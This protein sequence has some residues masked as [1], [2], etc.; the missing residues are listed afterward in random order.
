MIRRT[1]GGS[2]KGREASAAALTEDPPNTEADLIGIE[3]ELPIV[4]KPLE[5]LQVLLT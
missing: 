3:S 4:A 2:S 1:I 5:N